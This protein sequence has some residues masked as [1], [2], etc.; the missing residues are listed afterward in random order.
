[1]LALVLLLAT[2]HAACPSVSACRQY[3]VPCSSDSGAPSL[4]HVVNC[5]GQAAALGGEIPCDMPDNTTYLLLASI[6][7]ETFSFQTLSERAP[8]LFGQD[9]SFGS[10]SRARVDLSS[11]NIT[12]VTAG[13][14]HVSELWAATGP[15]QASLD[16][17]RNQIAVVDLNNATV[18]G[19]NLSRNNIAALRTWLHHADIRGDLDLSANSIDHISKDAFFGLRVSGSLNLSSNNMT[20]VSLGASTVQVVGTLDLSNNNIS[21]MHFENANVFSHLVDLS[22]NAI[23]EISLY[24]FRN[25]NF[26][27]NLSLSGNFISIIHSYTFQGAQFGGNLDLSNNNLRNITQ[28]AFADAF[29]HGDLRLTD[30]HALSLCSRAFANSV[31]LG[32]ISLRGNNITQLP[33]ALFPLTTVNCVDL[34][35]NN[36]DKLAANTFSL[37]TIARSLNLQRNKLTELGAMAFA[38]A[39]LLHNVDLS[40]NHI[41]NISNNRTFF[42]TNMANLSLAHNHLRILHRDTFAGVRIG[43]IVNLSHND[44]AELENGWFGAFP[45]EID[46]D[47]ADNPSNCSV[48]E[49]PDRTFAFQCTCVNNSTG[50]VLGNGAYCSSAACP[51]PNPNKLN[52]DSVVVVAHGHVRCPHGAYEYASGTECTI[53]CRSGYTLQPG[54]CGSEDTTITCLGGQWGYRPNCALVYA[55]CVRGFSALVVAGASAGSVVGTLFIVGIVYKLLTFRRRIRKQQYELAVKDHLLCA[56]GEQLEELRA[57][58]TIQP[59][60]LVLEAP[61]A[62]GA[63]G[64]VWQGQWNGSV[65]AVK[66]LRRILVDLDEASVQEFEAESAL[67]RTLRHPNVVAFFGA[68]SDDTGVPFLVCEYMTDSLRGLLRRERLLNV[69]RLRMAVDAAHG[70]AY[71]HARGLIHRDLKSGNL[72]VSATGVVKVA[73]FGTSKLVKALT[74]FSDDESL[75]GSTVVINQADEA[76]RASMSLTRGVG[77]LAWMAPEVLDGGHYGLAADVYSFGVVLWELATQVLPWMN[78]ERAWDITNAVLAGERPNLQ[79]VEPDSP[80]LETMICCWQPDPHDR[81]TF[82]MVLKLLSKHL[83]PASPDVVVRT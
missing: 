38:D 75:D 23:S 25:S 79:L 51:N 47:M 11:N 78:K 40:Y 13:T 69:R 24:A 43:G 59:G 18:N 9:L 37:A 72:L 8:W 65:V 50:N 29:I 35:D 42:N 4:C 49:L 20:T 1:M 74:G 45:L 81:P 5:S 3:D 63:F 21:V 62:S 22:N 36:I 80:L 27:H 66:K 53:K 71:L 10:G 16:L 39:L 44:I 55:S 52:N 34:S 15:L 17:S 33:E 56:Q 76:P 68:G 83:P 58:F 82:D 6:G 54:K 28:N 67:M 70:M 41:A 77:T 7:M 30:N 46:L 2:A 32:C 14:I 48:H 31:I 64:E 57:G 12:N 60:Q 73:D 19:S 61:I 26:L